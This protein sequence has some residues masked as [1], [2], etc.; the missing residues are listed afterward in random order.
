MKLLAQV[1]F[2]LSLLFLCF[3]VLGVTEIGQTVLRGKIPPNIDPGRLDD[4][5]MGTGLEPWTY[6]LAPSVLLGFVGAALFLSDR[7]K[8]STGKLARVLVLAWILLLWIA[9]V[10]LPPTGVR[11]SSVTALLF[12]ISA[13]SLLA[14]TSVALFIYF[15]RSW[16]RVQSVTNKGAYVLWLGFESLAVVAVLAY[17]LCRLL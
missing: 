12:I 5:Y 10:I 17:L 3:F 11:P 8:P 15:Y 1:A 14:A 7:F 4:I 9:A 2:G 13:C 16:K 6:G